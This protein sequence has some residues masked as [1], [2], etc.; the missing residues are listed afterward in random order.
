MS[1]PRWLRAFEPP[2]ADRLIR[3]A[4][5]TADWIESFG[6]I[7]G[8]TEYWDVQPGT[9]VA[10]D[11]LLLSRTCL[12]GGAAGIALFYMRLYRAVK[13]EKYL[14]RARAGVNYIIEKNRG[15]CEYMTD[16]TWLPGAYVGYFQGPAGG[17]YAA[18]VLY[19]LTGEERYRR[20]ACQAADDLILAAHEED[21]ALYWFGDYAILGEGGLI[22]F[23]IDLYETF[24]EQKYLTAAVKAGLY[25]VRKQEEAPR[26]GY[27]WYAM[28]TDTFP[29][30]R[31]AGGYFPG[32]EYGA[33]GCGYILACLYEHTGDPQFLLS[34]KRAAEY[35]MNIADYSEDFSAALVRYNDTYLTD[36][37]YLGVCQGP[38]G[39]SRL[40]FKLFRLT[41][42]S[43]YRDFVIALANGLI[44]SGAPAI[45]SRGYWHTNCY[46]C[47]A[48]GMLEF[49]I[50]IHRLTG[51]DLY[52]HAASETASVILGDSTEK[53]GQ[54]Y[55]YTT[56]NRHEPWKNDA[57]TGL[58]HGS[59]GCAGSLLAFA[60]HMDGKE[61]LPFYLEDPY[62][63]LYR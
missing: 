20:F 23:L 61:W 10:E 3:A 30:I 29:T 15:F 28:P 62:K 59:A 38:I 39:T 6:H 53:D 14:N 1:G 26:G 35:I 58:Y 46:C 49:F 7:D 12:Y 16:K 51:D 33:A 57:Y 56:W 11:E 21:G 42:E 55:W 19:L 45:H 60:R 47:G 41:G 18:K 24:K 63:V 13:D 44:R 37:Y 54:R 27:R 50:H 9:E 2:N 40:F 22:L 17:A 25:I 5:E 34:A 52:Y 4:E 8:D 32:F 48:P 31:Q 36:L 43:E